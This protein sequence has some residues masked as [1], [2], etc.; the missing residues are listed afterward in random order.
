MM[1]AVGLCDR[2]ELPEYF[3]ADTAKFL[4]YILPA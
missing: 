3:D 4:Q 1:T 2:D